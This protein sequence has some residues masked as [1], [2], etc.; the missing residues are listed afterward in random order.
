MPTSL[1]PS[2]SEV[3][4]GAAIPVATLAYFRERLRNRLHQLVL[5]EFVRQERAGSLTRADLARRIGKKPEQVTRWLGAPGNWTLD[6]VS[7]LLLGMGTEPAF[8]LTRVAETATVAAARSIASALHQELPQD[9]R[10]ISLGSFLLP[11]ERAQ[12]SPY[13]R[14][15]TALPDLLS[16]C[17]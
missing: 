3:Q 15:G 9:P 1:T 11:A 6:T 10:R 5:R 4:L 17:E 16:A 12:P 13:T 7:D 2:L 8:A 14:Q